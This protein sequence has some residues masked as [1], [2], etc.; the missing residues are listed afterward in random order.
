MLVAGAGVLLLLMLLLL[1]QRMGESE[2]AALSQPAPASASHVAAIPPAPEV[3][4]PTPAATPELLPVAT[5]NPASGNDTPGPLSEA[6][7]GALLLSGQR[8]Q[9]LASYRALAQKPG[10]HP[11][12]EAMVIV[13]EQKVSPL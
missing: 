1:P 13:L 6:Q 2:A 3:P 12:I 11:G 10:A 5:P 8:A 9:A 7:A 4:D